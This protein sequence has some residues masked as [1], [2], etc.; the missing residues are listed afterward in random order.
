MHCGTPVT[1]KR[2]TGEIVYPV[3]SNIAPKHCIIY[4]L[5]LPNRMNYSYYICTIYKIL[6]TVPKRVVYSSCNSRPKYLNGEQPLKQFD[7]DQTIIV[8]S[9][10]CNPQAILY[11]DSNAIKGV[12]QLNIPFDK[13]FYKIYNNRSAR[14]ENHDG[15]THAVDV[16]HCTL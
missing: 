10:G 3:K 9:T 2:K 1:S 16:Y 7:W 12:E 11:C 13:L 6:T 4:R 8:W 5:L 14:N 15:Q